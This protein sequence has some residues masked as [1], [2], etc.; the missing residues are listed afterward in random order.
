MIYFEINILKNIIYNIFIKI[1]YFK[2]RVSQNVS[3]RSG[4]LASE[5]RMNFSG[6]S[7][8]TNETMRIY[9]RGFGITKK[10]FFFALFAEIIFFLLKYSGES[11]NGLSIW[12]KLLKKFWYKVNRF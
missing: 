6:A 2:S 1:I 4:I 3:T 8:T 5:K 9:F 12:A 7:D 10:K 11:H